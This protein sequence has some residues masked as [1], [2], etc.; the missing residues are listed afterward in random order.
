M[1]NTCIILLREFVIVGWYVLQN[2]S[3]N[4][5]TEI[6]LYKIQL[7]FSSSIAAFIRVKTVQLKLRKIQRAYNTKQN[8]TSC[9]MKGQTWSEQG[10]CPVRVELCLL[11]WRIRIDLQHSEVAVPQSLLN[12]LPRPAS[13]IPFV[14]SSTSVVLFYSDKGSD[15]AAETS[16]FCIIK[17]LCQNSKI[18]SVSSFINKWQ[19]LKH[20]NF[21]TY[22]QYNSTNIYLHMHIVSYKLTTTLHCTLGSI[23]QLQLVTAKLHSKQAIL[24]N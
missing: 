2:V 24:A 8:N 12:N 22:I 20:E 11:H 5:D 3:Q 9:T 15:T 23:Q 6:V 13:C 14:F 10:G 4:S 21:I 19:K 16:V 1:C 17:F 18:Y 7:C